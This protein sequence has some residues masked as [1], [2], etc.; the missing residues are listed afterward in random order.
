[1]VSLQFEYCN[2]TGR[3]N[4]IFNFICARLSL[5]LYPSSHV[6][7]DDRF[8]SF[9]FL[10]IRNFVLFA[11]LC[12]CVVEIHLSCFSYLYVGWLLLDVLWMTG[13][14]NW[15]MIVLAY[16]AVAVA[17]AYPM[18]N[19]HKHTLEVGWRAKVSFI[20][21][22]KYWTTCFRWLDGSCTARNDIVLG[23]FVYSYR[24]CVYY[25]GRRDTW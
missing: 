3:P 23:I 17:R 2:D 8:V 6:A 10:S 5:F 13:N 4:K 11:Y 18:F 20:G 22:R 24:I 16:S 9:P 19:A 12:V 25:A 7:Y 1:M 15:N 14:L 21:S